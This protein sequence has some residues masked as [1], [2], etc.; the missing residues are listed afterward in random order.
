MSNEEDV[1]G[2][3]VFLMLQPILFKQSVVIIKNNNQ[4]LTFTFNAL[5]VFLGCSSTKTAHLILQRKLAPK[6]KSWY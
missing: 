5:W 6:D 3:I 1:H 4:R 2:T